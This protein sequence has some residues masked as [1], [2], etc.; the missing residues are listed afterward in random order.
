MKKDT[1]ENFLRISTFLGKTVMT[2]SKITINLGRNGTSLYSPENHS[3]NFF[4]VSIG[5]E[6]I[7][8]VKNV[9]FIVTSKDTIDML[10]YINRT[11]S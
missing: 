8:A 9:L 1:P 4:M 11:T 2:K 5:V 3:G 10:D 6:T 7:K